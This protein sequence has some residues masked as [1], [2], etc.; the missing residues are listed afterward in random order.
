MDAQ[1]H[2][3]ASPGAV[4]GPEAISDLSRPGDSS[5]DTKTP[6]V[7]AGRDDD[8]RKRRK[9]NSGE[10]GPFD[11]YAGQDAQDR[12]TGVGSSSSTKNTLYSDEPY[13]DAAHEG[14]DVGGNNNSS[15]GTKPTAGGDD[16]TNV[17]TRMSLP[18]AIRVN[19]N[20]TPPPS[21]RTIAD[22]SSVRGP[23][24]EEAV[25][26]LPEALTVDGALV[27]EGNAVR[28]EEPNE[29]TQGGHSFSQT[30][31]RGGVTSCLRRHPY[32]YIFIVVAVLVIIVLVSVL[33]ARSGNSDDSSSSSNSDN[34]LQNTQPKKTTDI[35]AS[36]SLRPTHAPS[37][38]NGL[39]SNNT[40]NY[41]G[42]TWISAASSC[43]VPCPLGLNVE[44]PE[45][46]SCFGD[47]VSCDVNKPV[48]TGRW[49]GVSWV[50]AARL[51]SSPCP[52]GIDAECDVEGEACFGDI[53]NCD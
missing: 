22:A 10:P 51:C 46:Q 32:R 37:S 50:E 26:G 47:L 41:C 27:L 42:S 1:R 4:V 9:T 14:S 24:E 20:G 18:G 21:L 38:S 19:P 48:V 8:G 43:D 33:V 23:Q 30:K 5:L 52:S 34:G 25:T 35:T 6:V 7:D 28:I 29:S 15:V 44:C 53:P 45:G 49:C 13:D 2:C 36:P 16:D 12:H 11:A 3:A 39:L 17:P 40:T 31:E